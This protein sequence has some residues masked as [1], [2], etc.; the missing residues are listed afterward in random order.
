MKRGTRKSWACV[1]GVVVL[2]L[3]LTSVSIHR[4]AAEEDGG[5]KR[6]YYIVREGDTLWAISERFYH[7]PYVWP[8]V[9]ANNP[10]IEN[11]H[12]I[13]PGDPVYLASLPGQGAPQAVA[14]TAVTEEVGEKVDARFP[15]AVEETVRVRATMVDAAVLSDDDLD[16]IGTVVAG[17]GVQTL[18]AQGDHLFVELADPGQPLTETPYQVVRKGREILHPVTGKRIGRLYH[19][20][21][22]VKLSPMGESEVARALVVSSRDAIE[23]GDFLRAASGPTGD[24]ESRRPTKSVDGYVLTSVKDVEEIAQHDICFL[25][26]GQAEGVEVGD[27]FWVM[28]AVGE[29]GRKAR[30]PRPDIPPIRVALLVVIHTEGSTSTA[31]V[32]QS[33]DAFSAGAPVVT[34][35]E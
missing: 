25:D 14:E 24:V 8:F 34:W 1:V 9:W 30:S 11:P 22:H 17:E 26:R 33:R 20:V 35:V 12:W 13:Y 23:V 4:T 28:K 16:A 6:A 7:D 27:M 2:S 15:P 19:I 5:A 18:F 29:S 31:V 21:G 10:Y 32:T 3:C